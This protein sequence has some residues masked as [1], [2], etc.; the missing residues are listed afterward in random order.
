M[1]KREGA[2]VYTKEGT[3]VPLSKY[4]GFSVYSMN[5]TRARK[6]MFITRANGLVD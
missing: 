5:K 2:Y 1:L 3:R 6:K 4:R